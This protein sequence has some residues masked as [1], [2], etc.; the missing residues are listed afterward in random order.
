MWQTV[1][2]E[3]PSVTARLAAAVAAAVSAHNARRGRPWREVG[4]SVG[5][6]GPPG[7]GNL[8]RYRRIDVAADGDIEAAVAAAIASGA[9]PPAELRR[10]PAALRLL[11]PVVSRLGDSFLVSNLGRHDVGGLTDVAFF[12][13][14]RGPSA[15]AVGAVGRGDGLASVSLRAR[16][17]DDGDAG[18]LLGSV[19]SHLS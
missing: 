4:V 18:T 10:A 11:A 7:V 6:G 5:L 15:V 16:H 8:A 19:I 13:V 12:P 3:G 17:L 9:P 2:L 14:A 1:A